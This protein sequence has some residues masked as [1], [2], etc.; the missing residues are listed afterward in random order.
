MPVKCTLCLLSVPKKYPD[1]MNAFIIISLAVCGLA[2]AG[3]YVPTVYGGYG[4]YG[5]HGIAVAGPHVPGSVISGPAIGSSHLAGPVSGPVHVSGAVAGSATVTGSV[6]GPAYVEG[7]GSDYDG[8]YD[9]YGNGAYAH[10]G[11]AHA[12]YAHTAYPYAGY[13]NKYVGGYGHGPSGVVI[14]GPAIHGS[15]YA[16]H[17]GYAPA[18]GAVYGGHGTVLAGPHSHGA[19]VAG[20]HS[21]NAAVSGPSAGD[22]VIQGPSGKITAHGAGH[23][24]AIHTGHY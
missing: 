9:V 24:A 16:S 13:A 19:V 12:G 22:V 8:S 3:S 7:Y 6:A 11:Y 18:H 4:G 14:A 21:G 20:P 10:G 15:V 2:N 1:K 23:G 5:A 17:S